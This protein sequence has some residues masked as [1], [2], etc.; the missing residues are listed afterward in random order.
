MGGLLAYG[1]L[2]AVE[3]YGSPIAA[4]R[5]LFLCTGILTILLGVAF[6]FLMPDS[7]LNA[8]FLSETDRILAIQR[9]RVNQ[10]GI[11]N[12]HFKRYQLIETLLDPVTWALFFF[13]LVTTISNGGLAG[14]FNQ[15]VSSNA[16]SRFSSSSSFSSYF[17]LLHRTTHG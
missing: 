12:R 16:S 11:G 17:P 7:Q 9:I 4:W 8:K 10:Q 13:A 1:I 5:L 6:L 3:R 14:F 15:V 2:K